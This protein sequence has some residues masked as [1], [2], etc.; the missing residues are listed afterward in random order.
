LNTYCAI[1]YRRGFN[2]RMDKQLA[3]ALHVIF[4]KKQLLF[5]LLC[6]SI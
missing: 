2:R 1:P 3:Y 6:G 5:M 4:L